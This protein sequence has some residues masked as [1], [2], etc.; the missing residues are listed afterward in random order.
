MT[1]TT[2]IFR[3][4]HPLRELRAR[5]A[6]AIGDAYA[7]VASSLLEQRERLEDQAA[8]RRHQRRS[9]GLAAHAAPAAT[10]GTAVATPAL[11]PRPSQ[12]S[13]SL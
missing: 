9:R 7:R 13:S 5:G 1:E 11:A 8:E 10:S 4:L 2:S 3:W 12:P 6:E